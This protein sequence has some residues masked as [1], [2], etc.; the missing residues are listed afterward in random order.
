MFPIHIAF[1]ADKKYIPYVSVSLYSILKSAHPED[2]LYFYIVTP[3]DLAV[4]EQAMPLAELQKIHPFNI[5]FISFDRQS[6]LPYCPDGK[7]EHIPYVARLLLPWLIADIDRIIYLDSD[8]LVQGSLKEF[9]YMD[10][11]G[12][13]ALGVEDI[14]AHKLH[15]PLLKEDYK[16]YINAGVILIDAKRWRTENLKEQVVSFVKQHP[17]CLIFPDQDIL[18]Y[19][20]W[21]KLKK[22]D[23]K[24]NFHMDFFNHIRLDPDN[25]TLPERTCKPV[26]LHYSFPIKPWQPGGI[27]HPAAHVW[28]TLARQCPQPIAGP[29]LIKEGWWILKKFVRFV[30]IHPG[31]LFSRKFW[32]RVKGQGFFPTI[33]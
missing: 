21:G 6:M 25:L 23:M 30:Y 8:L 5:K 26:V 4:D 20:L 13:Y 27:A 1:V 24:W 12:A 11:E 17:N 7:K 22:V 3:K 10:F 32:K 18:N 33:N 15:T 19:M 2:D 28:R 29:S 16:L 31:F 14:S 9:Y